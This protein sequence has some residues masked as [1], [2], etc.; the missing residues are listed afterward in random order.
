MSDTNTNN[1]VN[2]IIRGEGHPVILVHGMGSSLREWDGITT[3]LAKQ[4]FRTYAFDLLGHGESTKPNEPSA[5]NMESL[6]CHAENWIQSLAINEP[7]TMISHSMGGYISLKYAYRFPK[8][9]DKLVLIDPFFRISQ[10][11]APARLA[12][13][14]PALIA[15]IWRTLQSKIFSP[16]FKPNGNPFSKTIL[17]ILYR[18]AIDFHRTHPNSMYAVPTLQDLTPIL[19]HIPTETLVVWGG[20]DLTLAPR[21]FSE[22]ATRMPKTQTFKIESAGHT[23]HLTRA[24]QIIPVILNFLN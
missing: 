6:Y 20:L 8:S 21:S 1:K 9:V 14:R 22:L 2:A 13:K 23:L 4:G 10:L 7:F 5:Y 19:P 24:R 11:T 17:Q 16:I 15:R 12:L 18:M 3:E